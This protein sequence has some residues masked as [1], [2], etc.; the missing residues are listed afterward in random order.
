MKATESWKSERLDQEVSM[1][2]WGVVGKPVL[3]FPTAG[4][5]AEEIERFLVIDVLSDLLAEGRIKV[6]SVDSIAGRAMLRGDGSGRY[7]GWIQN[8]Y[9]EF[10]Y[11][12]VVPAVRQDCQ[13]D[14]VE[15]IVAGS[16]IGA[17]PVALLASS[18]DQVYPSTKRAHRS[19]PL[20]L[21]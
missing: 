12:E 20:R 16:S 6:Y 19:S 9:Q 15:L 2:R 18:C 17:L 21:M 14:D 3:I 13:A 10:I 5:D 4:G 7:R 11:H 1:A 8:R